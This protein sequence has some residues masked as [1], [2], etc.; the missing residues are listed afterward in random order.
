[1]AS[2]RHT[3]TRDKNS[4]KHIRA[5]VAKTG[6]R[7]T[8]A[9]GYESM[10]GAH[11]ET[12]ALSHV[13]AHAG[14]VSPST[15]EPLSESL[16]LGIGGGVG[17]GYFLFQYQG[18]PPSFFVSGRHGWQDSAGFVTGACKRLGIEPQVH[19]TSGAKVAARQ[20]E[21]TLAAGQPAVAWV[22]MYQ[23]PYTGLQDCAEQPL[24]VVFGNMYHVVVVAGM[25]DDASTY[26]VDDRA[27]SSAE[28]PRRRPRVI[29][30]LSRYPE[31]RAVGCGI[32]EL[33]ELV[34][35]R[36]TLGAVHRMDRHTHAHPHHAFA[37]P[38]KIRDLLRIA[39]AARQ[40]HQVLV[41]GI[42][43]MMP[44]RGSG[45]SHE[46]PGPDLELVI[47]DLGDAA[48]RQDE[49]ELLLAVM[50]VVSER[51]L[52]RRDAKQ[53]HAKASEAGVIAE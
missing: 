38:R 5:G 30:A 21:A 14:V 44:D 23:L 53:V 17:A 47:A 41:K 32:R 48:S 7:Y 6:E 49:N 51:F 34:E 11:A 29:L 40:V 22:N 16:I 27:A 26:F 13:L 46:V 31:R 19:E 24:M 42:A 2:W 50:P 4:R 3:V 18:A 9:Q 39:L 45:E 33:F 52:A 28:R 10:G 35:A 15:G 36:E 8:G 25:D 12:A 20:L 37:Q 1:M 43:Q